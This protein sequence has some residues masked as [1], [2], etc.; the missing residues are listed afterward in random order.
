MTG[1]NKWDPIWGIMSL[2]VEFRQGLWLIPSDSNARPMTEGTRMFL[3]QAASFDPKSHTGDYLM[4]AW[5]AR[6]ALVDFTGEAK[7]REW[8]VAIFSETPQKK[9]RGR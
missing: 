9:Q 6:Q 5:L 7:R 1:K 4:A 8:R 3:Q 2:T